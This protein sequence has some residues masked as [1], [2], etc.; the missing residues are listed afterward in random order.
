MPGVVETHNITVLE[1]PAGLAITL[2]V[3]VAERMSLRE[4]AEIV[5][6]LKDEIRREFGIA[7]VYAHVEPFAPDAQPAR[8]VSVEEP[9]LQR[10][11][12]AAVRPLVGED[13]EVVVYRQGGRLLVVTS[14]RVAP[15]LSVREAHTIASRIEDAVRDALAD[16][17]DVIVEVS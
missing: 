17:D 13:P 12:A 14:A 6:R 11:A 1:G 10:L 8:D 5:E 2:H 16:V 3:R 15:G 4:A 9:Q 7:R